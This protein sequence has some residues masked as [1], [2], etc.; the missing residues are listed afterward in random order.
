M[1]DNALEQVIEVD[2]FSS[3]VTVLNTFLKSVC[4]LYLGDQASPDIVAGLS[5]ISPLTSA[6]RL[7]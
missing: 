5:E 3:F 1:A 2:G 6:A 7:Q 4:R